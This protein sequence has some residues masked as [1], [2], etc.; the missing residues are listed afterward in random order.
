MSGDLDFHIKQV[1]V[2]G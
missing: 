1:L 2:Y